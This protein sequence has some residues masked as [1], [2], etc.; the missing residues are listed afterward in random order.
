MQIPAVW[1]IVGIVVAAFGLAP[2]AIV[3]GWLALVAF[4]LLGEFGSLFNLNH[5]V[6]DISPFAHVPRLPGGAFSVAP[7]VWL[8]VIA[9]G[10]I[11]V[12]LAGFR[13]RDVG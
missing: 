12:G 1:L 7:M 13:R 8:T 5:Y 11:V 4:M 2:R 3:A 9:A 6:M 10:L